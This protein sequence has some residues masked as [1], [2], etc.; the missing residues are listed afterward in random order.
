MRIYAY[1]NI[2]TA[3]FY[4]KAEKELADI[5]PLQILKDKENN[6]MKNL[7]IRLTCEPKFD[8]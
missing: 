4:T 5:Y 1:M 3:E 7:G 2:Y 6:A 8:N